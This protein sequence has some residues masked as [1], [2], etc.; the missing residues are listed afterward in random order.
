MSKGKD[1]GEAVREYWEN[2]NTV[3]IIDKNLH[4]IEMDTVCR[5]L[6]PTDVLADVGCG[7]GEATVEYAK[8]VH[9]CVGIERS[10]NLREKAKKAAIKSGLSNISIEEGDVLNMRNRGEKYDAIVTQR[11]LINLLS[12]EEQKKGIM[13]IYELLKPGG[14]YIMVE[15]TS[16]AFSSLNEMRHEVGLEPIP[17]H[18]HNRFFDYDKLMEFMDSK[19]QLVKSYDFGLYYFLTRVYTPMYASFKGYGVK[20]VKDPIYERSDAA[21][22][23]MY[24]KFNDII[25]IGGCRALGPIQAFVFRREG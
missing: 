6:M 16:D 9:K 18:W 2:P 20:A 3:S 17:Q 5:H 12:W 23:I 8:K 4:K 25:R 21:A 11:V 14:R 22:R 15:N 10:K 7:D 24:E 19:F 13:N 1:M